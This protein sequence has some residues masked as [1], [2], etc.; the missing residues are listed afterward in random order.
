MLLMCLD[1]TSTETN[2]QILT[3]FDVNVTSLET[4]QRP[5]NLLSYN[6]Y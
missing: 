1:P 6:W 5:Y 3:K 2:K 4:I